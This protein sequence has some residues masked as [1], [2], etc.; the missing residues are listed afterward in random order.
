MVDAEVAASLVAVLT[1]FL[2]VAELLLLVK[3]HLLNKVV[4]VVA[5]EEIHQLHK[6]AA[7]AIEVD[8]IVEEHQHEEPQIVEAGHTDLAV[9]LQERKDAFTAVQSIEKRL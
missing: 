8:Q 6:A 4:V 3:H 9:D 2:Q 7:V 5:V 1:L